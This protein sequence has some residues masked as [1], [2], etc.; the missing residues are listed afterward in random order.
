[1]QEAKF[2][3]RKEAARRLRVCVRTLDKWLS[4]R[5]LPVI[6]A[7]RR[8]LLDIGDVDDFYRRL[9]VP[10]EAGTHGGG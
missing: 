2:L 10:A 5:R 8:V 1:M 7:G 4:E 3:E 9:K 6:K